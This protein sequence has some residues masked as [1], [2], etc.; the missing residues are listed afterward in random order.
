[1]RETHPD[2]LLKRKA[3]YLRHKTGNIHL[4]LRPESKQRANPKRVLLNA[5]VRPITLLLFSPIVTAMSLYV[6]FVFGLLYLL[7]ATFSTV[8]AGVYRFNVGISGLAYM[9]LGVGELVGLLIFGLLT[10]K[11][12]KQKMLQHAS[13]ESKPEHRLVMMMWFSPIIPVG[14]FIYGWTVYYKVHWIAPIIGTFFIGFGSFFVIVSTLSTCS[15]PISPFSTS[16]N[17]SW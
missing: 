9:G 3:A 14:F 6:A 2:V 7:L 17:M 5:L 4:V 10:D 11:I 13:K 8:F 1:M 12:S 15:F 16:T